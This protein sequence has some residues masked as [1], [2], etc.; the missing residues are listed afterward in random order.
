LQVIE[1]QENTQVSGKLVRILLKKTKL[2]IK[3][4]ALQKKRQRVR[5]EKPINTTHSAN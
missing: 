5:L 3:I 4:C 2:S 1:T